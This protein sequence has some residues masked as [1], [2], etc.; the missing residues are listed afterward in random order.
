MSG[1]D[2]QPYRGMILRR[3]SRPPM[4]FL[5]PIL[6]L[7]PRLSLFAPSVLL[8]AERHSL[9]KPDPLCR[10]SESLIKWAEP[11]RDNSGA[12]QNGDVVMVPFPARHDM[13][14]QVAFDSGPGRNPDVPS[15]IEALGFND[16][17][18]ESFGV[19]CHINQLE[20]FLS[21]QVGECGHGA[22]WHRHEMPRRIWI[23]IHDQKARFSPIDNIVI[24]V[25][26]AFRG[27]TKKIRSPIL[28]FKIF[29]P[30]GCP[31]TF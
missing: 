24:G 19:G 28:P 7:R 20:L 30:P 16:I 18:Q 5:T 31:K 26:R 23:Q 3:S 22:V 17:A 15:D 25:V 27:A 12:A 21:R 4:T 13:K 6:G 14:M 29:D 9:P 10:R 8:N 2:P 11:F 1:S